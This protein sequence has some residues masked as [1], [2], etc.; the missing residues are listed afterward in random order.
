MTKIKVQNIIL[1]LFYKVNTG[2]LFGKQWGLYVQNKYILKA[3]Y[4]KWYSIRFSVFQLSPGPAAT[5]S[6]KPKDPLA[7]LNLKDLM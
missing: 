4:L 7:D 5:Q 6:K 1:R 2:L 3:M